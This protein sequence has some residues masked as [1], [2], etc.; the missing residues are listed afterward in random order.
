M[1]AKPHIS[2]KSTKHQEF[3]K[4]F[5]R[6]KLTRTC[7]T[8][9]RIIPIFLSFSHFLPLSCQI[10]AVIDNSVCSVLKHFRIRL[11]IRKLR[12]IVQK[13]IGGNILTYLLLQCC[14]YCYHNKHVKGGG[15]CLFGKVMREILLARIF[16]SFILSFY[17]FYISL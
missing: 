11:F 17:N 13:F 3:G 5:S 1:I 10:S 6:G 9:E 15:S 16:K 8:E 14:C 12:V 7:R 4:R 2:I